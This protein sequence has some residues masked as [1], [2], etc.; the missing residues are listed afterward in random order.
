MNWKD[1]LILF[2]LAITSII[3]FAAFQKAPGYMDAEYY[4]AMGLRIVNNHTLSEP[5]A[6]NYLNGF[7][8]LP[9]PGFTFWM[10]APA[11]LAGLSMLIT[12]GIGF[13]HA[14][15]GFVITSAFIPII[16]AMATYKVTGKKEIGLTAGLLSVFSGFYAPFLTTIDSF[17]MIMLL[18]GAY[19]LVAQQ[20]TERWKFYLM[21]LMVG[22]MHLSRAD[23]FIWIIPAVFIA[24][25]EKKNLLTR[26]LL[27]FFGYLNVM[28]PWFIRN[29]V[30][31]GSPLPPGNSRMFWL[32]SY[33]DLFLYHIESLNFI[34]WSAQGLRSIIN[35]ISGALFANLKTALFIQGQIILLP[36]ILIGLFD[37]RKNRTIR[38]LVTTWIFAF[39]VMTVVFPFA[40][41]R[42]GFF[43]SGAAFQPVFWL[44]AA[45]GLD[46]FIHWG[47]NNRRWK[48]VQARP[49]LTAGLLVILMSVTA[50][51]HNQRVRGSST[52]DVQ[53]NQGYL[54]AI[55]VDRKLEDLNIPEGELVMINNPP[56]LYIASGRSAIT[57][58]SGGIHEIFTAAAEAQAGVLILESNH[59]ES[60]DFLFNNPATQDGF[61]LMMVDDQIQYYRIILAAD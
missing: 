20:C 51:V 15:A 12:R 1:Y 24:V 60:L 22:L 35:N 26:F 44:L 58:P 29:W 13:S 59:P 21:G 9:Q 30:V 7:S 42:G 11:F 31:L 50:F 48:E 33:D 18:G 19:L 49:I 14:R 47:I 25:S 34:T 56:G 61:D 57:I 43:H 55:E 45:V 5:F 40:G 32:T 36:L 28:F 27:I 53:W 4:Y 54:A 37:Y 6:W 39:V 17:G 46:R 16:V 2:F 38:S 3:A 52:K 10:P 8:G 41:S 23:G